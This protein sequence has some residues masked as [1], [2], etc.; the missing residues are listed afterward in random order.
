MAALTLFSWNVRQVSSSQWIEITSTRQSDQPDLQ[1]ALQQLEAISTLR[2]DWDSYGSEP[3]TRDAIFAARNLIASA[4]RRFSSVPYFVAPV[5][6][7]GVQIEWR[8]PHREIEVE[9]QSDGKRF[10]YLLIE[11]KGTANRKAEEKHDISPSQI[12]NVIH[13]VVS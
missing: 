12:L 11:G 13:S 8:G 4:Y 9:L 3:P 6:G 10:N 2:K 1:S 5:S 7:G